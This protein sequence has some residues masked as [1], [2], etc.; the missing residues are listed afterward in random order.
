MSE[1]SKVLL[2]DIGDFSD[3]EVVEMHVAVGD[4]VAVEDS[5]LTLESDKATMDVPSPEAGVVTEIVV[6][7]GDTI[8]EGD[9]LISLEVIETE[10]I[11]S[12]SAV[13]QESVTETKERVQPETEANTDFPDV[14][15]NDSKA[16][17][18]EVP[19]PP[20]SLPPP[21][22]RAKL[23]L[24]HA[25]PGVRR[26]ARQL[27]ADLAEVRGTGAK[28]R[29]LRED[30]QSHVKHLLQSGVS[31]TGMSSFRPPPPLPEVDFS[32]FGK[33]E[34]VKLSKIKR[35]TG[36]RLHRSWIEIP[37]V[38]HHDEAD[39]TKLEEFR[40]A[41]DLEQRPLGTRVTILSFVCKAIVN[42][43]QRF[44]SFNA[45]LSPDNQSLI[46]KKY[47]NIGVAVDTPN[48]LVV[49]VIKDIQSLGIINTA[50][51][52]QEYGKK[53]REG[54]L[55]PADFEGGCFTIS[56]LGGIGGRYFTPIINPPEVAILGIS[57]HHKKV[58]PAEDKGIEWKTMLPLSL[59]YD[60]RVIDGA[61]AA[62]FVSY[63]CELLGDSRR[64]LL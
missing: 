3:V 32:K 33:T 55:T 6:G 29:I 12:E 40:K 42:A 46:L 19:K 36:E 59:S 24:P 5:I 25:S 34:T 7:L 60:H 1:P 28:G 15:K 10:S 45:S 47:F 44:P 14:S 51:S 50:K 18:F 17:S 23:A 27:G 31:D 56:S 63:L 61:E 16:F 21:V 41:I 13:E 4:N 49:P 62:R 54:Q 58:T 38:T 22:E 30:V 26:F 2:P 35:I 8:S 52:L 64:I 57:R 37:H 48:G 39:I 11:E 43:L 53:A 20:P 9:H